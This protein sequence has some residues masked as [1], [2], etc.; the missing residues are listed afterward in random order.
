MNKE[1]GSFINGKPIIHDEVVDNSIIRNYLWNT[2]DGKQIFMHLT[3]TLQQSDKNGSYLSVRT[4]ID[5]S[6]VKGQGKFLWQFLKDELRSLARSGIR[7]IPPS[8]ILHIVSPNKFSLKLVE[9]DPEYVKKGDAYYCLYTI[10][11][12]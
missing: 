4:N 9:E 10:L 11:R 8:P 12:D 1:K 7:D 5:S 6:E 3:I 2:P